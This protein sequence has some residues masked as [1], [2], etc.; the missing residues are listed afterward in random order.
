MQILYESHFCFIACLK[1]HLREQG[2]FQTWTLYTAAAS[3]CKWQRSTWVKSTKVESQHWHAH[4]VRTI[5]IGQGG[6]VGNQFM[7][8]N[9]NQ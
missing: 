8:N 5:S 9:S 1:P 4:C 2:P 3:S 6:K 7:G